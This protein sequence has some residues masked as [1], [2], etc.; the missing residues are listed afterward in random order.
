MGAPLGNQYWKL[1][2]KHGRDRIIT[3]P[4]A[5]EENAEQYFQWCIDNPLL[6]VDYR[7]KDLQMVE[8]PK[9]RVFQKS[10]LALACGLSSWR[11]IE[12]LKELSKDFLQVITRIEEIIYTQ[13]FE[14][15][16][17]GFLNPNVIARDLGLVDK[18]D[19]NAN[20]KKSG[21]TVHI[22]NAENP[23]PESESDVSG[24]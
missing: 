21:V 9:L 23:I 24:Q 16:A 17:A 7:G 4:K 18:Q 22:V 3:D 1:R 12:D 5:L 13:K 8:L 6:E 10:G 19:I 11:T 15:T 2:L 14:G 20:V